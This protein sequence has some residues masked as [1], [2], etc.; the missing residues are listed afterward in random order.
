MDVTSLDDLA[1]FGSEGMFSPEDNNSNNN[2]N[3]NQ[4]HHKYRHRPSTPSINP[5][6]AATPPAAPAASP[7]FDPVDLSIGKI[8]PGGRSF[9]SNASSYNA[10]RSHESTTAGN[11]LFNAVHMHVQENAKIPNYNKPVDRSNSSNIVH[12]G[13]FHN[14]DFHPS[15]LLHTTS[16]R[17]FTHNKDNNNNINNGGMNQGGVEHHSED[18]SMAELFLN[19]ESSYRKSLNQNY[20]HVG[21]LLD[22]IGSDI[23]RSTNSTTTNNMPMDD[24]TETETS[25]EIDALTAAIDPTPWAEIEHKIH[26]EALQH[27]RRQQNSLGLMMSTHHHPH[28]SSYYPYGRH[29]QLPIPE[30]IPSP[31]IVHNSIQQQQQLLLPSPPAI[32]TESTNNNGMAQAVAT[33]AAIVAVAENK[34]AARIDPKRFPT[35]STATDLRGDDATVANSRHT[36]VPSIGSQLATNTTLLDVNPNKTAAAMASSNARIIPRHFQRQRANSATPPTHAAA[37]STNRASVLAA[38]SQKSQYGFGGDHIV[39]SVPAP[40]PNHFDHPTIISATTPTDKR[41]DSIL[42]T[43]GTTQ[44]HPPATKGPQTKPSLPA[45]ATLPDTYD[46]NPQAI[47]S[48]MAYE[49]KK[50]RAKDARVKLNES[51]DRLSISISLAGSQSV[52]RMKQLQNGIGSANSAIR[53]KTIQSNKECLNLAE[54]AKKWDR[55]SFVGT[56]ASLIQALNGQCEALIAE[57]VALQEMQSDPQS[58]GN[59]ST[60]ARRNVDAD[61]GSP[62]SRFSPT[63]KKHSRL[64]DD[65]LA[66]NTS[67]SIS[68]SPKYGECNSST[69]QETVHEPLIKRVRVANSNCTSQTSVQCGLTSEEP[70]DE[71]TVFRGVSRFLDPTSLCRSQC[72]SKSWQQRRC[73]RDDDIWLELI[74]RRFG[75]F[76]VRQWRSKYKDFEDNCKSDICNKS[77]YRDMHAA[78]VMPHFNQQDAT[79]S[80]LGDTS[81]GGKISGWVFLVERSN[82]ETLRSV[83]MKPGNLDS[84][85]TYQ[86]RPVVELKFVIQNTGVGEFP[87]ILKDQVVAVDVS[88]RRTG[89]TMAEIGWDDRFRKVVRNLDGTNRESYRGDTGGSECCWKGEICRLGLYEAVVLDVHILADGCSTTSKFKQKSNFA[90]LLVTVDGRTTTMVIPFSEENGR[91][92]R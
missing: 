68:G 56:A 44:A 75:I 66:P 2:N 63:S 91:V 11:L 73:F 19:K 31:P 83:K 67:V 27:T 70:T 18:F 1:S 38:A 50:Q 40:P 28:Q 42:V 69:D 74:V 8:S 51:I 13:F 43:T 86:S 79:L 85:R 9:T 48:G 6:A 21:S 17:N 39:P 4:K 80:K 26:K 34:A 78:N 14:F 47:N 60:P 3:N 5:L 24:E 35:S 22:T 72:V 77:L 20:Q 29:D 33:A 65:T 88:T 25:M 62:A 92:A 81:I 82:G 61:A 32:H 64:P 52:E 12:K 87:V 37:H 15:T 54:Q 41:M 10:S 49:R 46:E 36:T 55:P 57:L 89:G 30:R 71:E 59:L 76:N 84:G 90:N 53:Q 16:N 7:I 23:T 58:T 45:T